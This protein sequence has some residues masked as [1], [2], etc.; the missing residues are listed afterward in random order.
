MTGHCS[1]FNATRQFKPIMRLP[2]LFAACMLLFSNLSFAQYRRY[3]EEEGPDKRFVVG[4][5]PISLLTRGGKVNLRGEWVYST[6]K[7]LSLLVAVPWSKKLPGWL[8]EDL[9]A[10]E[11][12]AANKVTENRYKVVGAVLENRFYLGKKAPLGFYLAP[13]LRYNRFALTRTTLNTDNGGETRM[14]GAVGGFGIGGA[15]GAQFKLAE[16]MTLDL[17]FAGFDLKWM[18]GSLTYKTSDPENNLTELRDRVQNA[19]GDI[20]IIGS[21]LAA[22]IEGDRVKVHA[23]LGIWPAYRFNLTVN[24]AF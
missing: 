8:E 24:C 17:T 1:R 7:S 6:N 14:T 11:N 23:P 9:A 21:R 3:A 5:A 19:V 4:F 15:A 10:E 18:R 16:F 12:S 20:P 22:K 13:Y 2:V